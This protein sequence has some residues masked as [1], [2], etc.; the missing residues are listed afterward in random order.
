MKTL[1]AVGL[2]ALSSM[3]NGCDW[4][5]GPPQ[6]C[7]YAQ[8]E[9]ALAVQIWQN[10]QQMQQQQLQ[11]RQDQME[12]DQRAEQQYQQQYQAQHQFDNYRPDNNPSIY[13]T[14][15]YGGRY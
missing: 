2:L 10:D 1:I 13:G 5:A 9:S 3:A 8:P 11:A 6:P 14:Q 12:A 15:V 4:I 7:V